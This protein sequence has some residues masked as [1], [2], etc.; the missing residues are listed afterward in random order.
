M[1]KFTVRG[2]PCSKANSRA[3]VMW[4]KRPALIKSADALQYE[5][6]F[7][8][9]MPARARVMF[10]VPVRVTL[11]IFYATERPDLD[12]SLVLD[13]MQARYKR[14]KGRLEQV[15]DAGD[16]FAYGK[17]ERKLISRGVYLNDRLVREKH[18]Y[19][20]IDKNNPRTE[21]EV[22]LITPELFAEP[23]RAEFL[24][25]VT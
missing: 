2:Q 5:R 8:L 19:H 4:G 21:I 12:E 17:G 25:G 14:I 15:D 22:D 20:A 11:R 1:I 6:D 18:V 9:Q 7:D 23:K 10:D 13:C 24:E 16:E 3:I